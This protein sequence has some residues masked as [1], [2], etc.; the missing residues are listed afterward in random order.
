MLGYANWATLELLKQKYDFLK[1]LVA[2]F[3]IRCKEVLA[4]A[5]LDVFT[6]TDRCILGRNRW[7]G[8]CL[9]G[10]RP[11]R[12]CGDSQDGCCMLPSLNLLQ[13]YSSPDSNPQAMLKDLQKALGNICWAWSLVMTSLDLRSRKNHIL[14]DWAWSL[15]WGCLC[16]NH[17]DT[18]PLLSWMTTPF[19]RLCGVWAK[20]SGKRVSS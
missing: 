13:Y 3:N 19:H 11:L 9:Q 8:T 2:R 4:F 17:S 16:G 6:K 18:N 5:P 15:G 7:S 14:L 1:V 20:G 10:Q 12:I